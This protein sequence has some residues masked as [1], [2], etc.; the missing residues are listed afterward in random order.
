MDYIMTTA[1]RLND[2]ITAKEDMKSAIEEKG[3]EVTGGL[4]SYA[5]AINSLNTDYTA[6]DVLYIPAGVNIGMYLNGFTISREHFKNVAFDITDNPDFQLALEGEYPY[7]A[8]YKI[9]QYNLDG[10]MIKLL[11]FL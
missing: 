4:T 3:V 5:D 2:L 8:G 11:L 9:L 10:K 6:L 7:S 1:D